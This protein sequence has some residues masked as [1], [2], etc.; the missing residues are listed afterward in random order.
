VHGR[1]PDVD[2]RP[3]LRVEQ[4]L[5]RQAQRLRHRFLEPWL[6]RVQRLAEPQLGDPQRIGRADVDDRR[7]RHR[8]GRL[9]PTCCHDDGP[10]F[11]PGLNGD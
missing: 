1:D 4:P 9:H 10:L 2:R 7:L 3:E 6:R 8:R 5:E 11:V